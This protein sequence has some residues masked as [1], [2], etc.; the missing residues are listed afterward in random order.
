MQSFNK[1]EPVL[2]VSANYNVVNH[3]Q[4]FLPLLFFVTF[5]KK[6]VVSPFWKEVMKIKRPINTKRNNHHGTLGKVYGFGSRPSYKKEEGGVTFNKYSHKQP[7]KVLHVSKDEIETALKNEIALAFA[8]LDLKLPNFTSVVISTTFAMKKTIDTVFSTSKPFVKSKFKCSLFDTYLLCFDS[9]TEE[10]HSENDASWT[11]ITVPDQETEK[12]YNL[13]FN[14]AINNSL[15]VLINYQSGMA[16]TYAGKY[17]VHNQSRGTE[18]TGSVNICSYTGERTYQNV[19]L[20]I[21]REL[22]RN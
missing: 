3:N 15:S 2:M 11:V 18:N 19:C 10:P 5:E 6:K 16:L 22:N 12:N 17:I 7:K 14:V 8:D 20:S 9:M 1:N 13:S 4:N 21:S